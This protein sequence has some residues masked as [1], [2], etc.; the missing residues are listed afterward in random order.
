[1]N[2][3]VT[4]AGLPLCGLA[5]HGPDQRLN[6]IDPGRPVICEEGVVVVFPAI[7]SGAR[8]PEPSD[9]DGERRMGARRLNRSFEVEYQRRAHD[10]SAGQRGRCRRL[11]TG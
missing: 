9:L 10:Q 8:A 4:P 2:D 7:C 3:A 6:L 1:M 5:K 11:E